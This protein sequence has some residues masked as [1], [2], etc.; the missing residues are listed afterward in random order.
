MT[1]RRLEVVLT[2]KDLTQRAFTSAQGRITRMAKSALSLQAA[3]AAV[4][5]TAGIG[6]VVKN[7]LQLND[8]LAKTADKLGLTTEALAGLRHAAELTGVA[9]NTMDMALQRMVRRVAEAAA[10]TGEARAAIAE[11]G[12]DAKALAAIPVDQQF[13][14]IAQRMQLVENQADRVRLA[15]KLFD[16]EG[17]AVVNTLRLGSEGLKQA[18][19]DADRL[20]VAI[21]RVDAAQI[22]AAVDA[23]HRMQQAMQGLANTLTVSVAPVISDVAEATSEWVAANNEFIKSG[24]PGYIDTVTTAFGKYVEMLKLAYRYHPANLVRK[25]GGGA[26]D[27]ARLAMFGIDPE[28]S[29]AAFR[30][31]EMAG[32]GG[33]GAYDFGGTATTGGGATATAGLLGGGAAAKARRGSGQDPFR[34][35]DDAMLDLRAM[36]ET[37]AAAELAMEDLGDKGTE[38]MRN[39]MASTNMA[40]FGMQ[41]SMRQF[42]DVSSDGFLSLENLAL[43]VAQSIQQAFADFVTSQIFSLISGA[44][45]GGIGG[46]APSGFLPFGGYRAAGGPVAPGSAYM[47][48]ER[49]PELF[50]PSSAGSIQTGGATVINNY[51]S[52]LDAKSFKQ[53]FG[54]HVIDINAQAFDDND[55]RLW[56]AIS[57]RR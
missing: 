48:G 35:R 25:I 38:S 57:K 22:E 50:V 34:T 53:A 14:A 33:A 10:G 54:A 29:E 55:Q 51:I 5:G 23:G 26:Y 18:A 37:A 43:G 27:R 13:A 9:S 16:S 47:V 1:D 30:G 52:T 45:T 21:S 56:S 4:A 24:L 42:F 40:T 46:G 39:I 19:A 36:V 17:V 12:L 6:L 7:T 11:L 44:V 32:Y 8:R 20:G 41:S 28:A 31:M 2:A 3:F 15:F 49:G